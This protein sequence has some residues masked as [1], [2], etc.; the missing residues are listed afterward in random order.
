MSDNVLLHLG[1]EPRFDQIKTEDIKPALQTAI[2]EARKQIAAIKAQTHTDWAN[3]V[4]KLTDITERVGRIWSVVSH[5]NSVVDT[6]ELRAVY[7][8]L[9]PEITIF[10]T[11]I[12]QDI[13]LYNRFKI[14]KNSAE[15]DTL[16]PAQQTKLNHDLRDFVLSGAELPPE[17]QAELAQLQTE[18]AQLGAK[19]AQNIQDATD[20]FGIHFDDAAPLAGI[21]EDSLAMFAAAAQSEGKTGYKIGLQIPH[22]LAVIQYA[23][24]RELRE[25]IY[26]AYVTRASELSDDGKFDNTA[27]IDRTLENALKT[28]KLLG[29]KNY[30]ELSL[31]TKMADT[32]EQV[33][34]FL[35][36]LARRAKPF[37]EKDF[38]EIKAFARESLNIEDPQSWDLSY[39]AEKLRQAK[40]AFSETEVKKYFPIS[41]VLAGL[42][43]QIKKLYGIELAEKTVPVWHKDV[44]YFELKQDG[45]TIGGVYMDLYA[46]EGKR[47]GAWM[48]G[49][50]SRRRFAD[51][52]L[53]LPTAYLVC[54]FTPP[55]GD[56]EARLSH[57]EIITLFHETGHG[58]HHLL[59]QVDEV[60]VSG[61][62][63]V[64]W[65]AVELP[66]QFMENFVWEYDVLAQM[67][68]HEETGAVLPKELFD[69]MHAA[70]NFQRGMFL[71][72]QMEFALFDMEIYHQEDEG[73]LK[74]WP[75][76]LDKV[77]QEVAVTQ[78]PAYNRF[79][80]SFSHIFAGGYSA[81]YYSYAW[82]EVL[83]ADAYAAFEESDDVAET[84]RRFWKEILAVGGSRNAAESFKAFRGREP[85]LDAL[86]RHSGFDNAA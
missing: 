80:L 40:Y 34:N 44:R 27:N 32:P 49:Y 31:A 85:S 20:A 33:L 21:P 12:G 17:Q 60:G 67:S 24:N 52:T 26:R 36:D 47:G 78:P 37:A 74:E 45:Q 72:R 50:K 16:S 39:A 43:A 11:E 42:F 59:T 63:G 57:D 48:D 62:N 4:E 46:R 84:G 7:N 81:G 53:Q 22:Y 35:H 66:S 61:I 75:Q 70:K 68:S 51:G 29:F 41:K 77:R 65:D 64:E 10:F 2:A 38:A 79:A 25:Q 86:L 15:F 76:I 19:F 71:V 28:A 83:S 5:L 30:A 58:L 14:I 13:E 23:D 6:P 18:G 9:M 54:N 69:K 55:V 82:A 1:E 56:K 3:T 8:E 73:R